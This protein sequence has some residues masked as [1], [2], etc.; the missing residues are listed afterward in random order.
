[1]RER[2]AQLREE[3]RRTGLEAL[4]VSKP[5]NIR[6][7]CGATG[8]ACELLVTADDVLLLN[9]YVDITQNQ[10]TAPD[11]AQARR[12]DP[13][14]DVAAAVQ[15]RQIQ[16]IGLEAHVLPQAA[17]AA[18][19]AAMPEVE[20][21]STS[22][23]VEQLR[24]VKGADEVALIQ[25][26]MAINDLGCRYVQEHARAGI[27]EG[28]LA[29]GVERTMRES[30]A[31]RLAFLL[32]QFG[33]NAAKP[34]H[35]FSD[36][37]L[38]RGDLILCDIGAVCEG[39][40]SD[41]T[42]TF[43]FG[44]ASKRQRIVYEAVRTAQLAA[45]AAV[46]AGRRAADVHEASRAVI[47]EAGYN[48]YY[49]HGVGHGI[50]EGPT[51]NPQSPQILQP[52]NVVTIEPGIYIPGWGGVRIEDTVVVTDDGCRNLADF[53]KELTVITTVS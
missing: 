35:T 23:L 27:S 12:T 15:A 30:G 45:L 38:S 21:I 46:K 53:P 33:S 9:N 11:V 42:R 25:R 36:R 43:V 47:A 19:V 41:T 51:L 6:Y 3:L 52:G 24:W 37:A 4:L 22:G 18:Y 13:P 48:D 8:T 7:L 2:I 10:E 17:Y 31:E 34:H 28:E 20:V 39:Y 14:Q 1:M 26:G 16:H 32:I 49:G 50:N 44:A 5:A 40:G 29:L